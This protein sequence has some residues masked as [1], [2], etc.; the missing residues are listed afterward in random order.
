MQRKEYAESESDYKYKVCEQTKTSQFRLI[1]CVGSNLRKYDKIISGCR[2]SFFFVHQV[3]REE[4]K[5]RALR[6]LK[7]FTDPAG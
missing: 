5:G 3:A 1:H 7:A 2:V 6:A 4:R